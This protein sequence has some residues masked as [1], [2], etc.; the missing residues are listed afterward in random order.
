VA[1][2]FPQKDVNELLVSCHRRCCICHR[3]CGVKIETDHIVP[4]GDGGPSSIENAI[5][6]CF[7]CHAEIHGYNDKHPR[8]RKFRP[9][10]LR[11]HRDQW[12]RICQQSPTLLLS[13]G[14]DAAVGPIQSLVDE[15]E[16]N[17]CVAHSAD[18]D[19][20]GCSFR[21]NEFDRAIREGAVA[22]LHDDLKRSVLDAYVAI[23]SAEHSLH[24]L[25]SQTD[26]MHQNR[27]RQ[28]CAER[29]KKVAER[30]KAARA[31]LLQFLGHENTEST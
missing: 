10:E 27:S 26:T 8:G 28:E 29:I 2:C 24:M 16:F 3:Y 17:A 6:V 31:S 22:I 7:E 12:L 4:A 1:T 19:S 25:R 18:A 23:G 15:I 14:P 11:A 9:D 30:C 5:A 13:A 20:P 21:Q